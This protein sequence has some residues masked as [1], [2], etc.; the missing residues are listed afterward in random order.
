MVRSQAGISSTTRCVLF[1]GL[2]QFTSSPMT[3]GGLDAGLFPPETFSLIP[4]LYEP[5]VHRLFALADPSPLPHDDQYG[6]NT[7]FNILLLLLFTN[8]SRCSI[9]PTITIYDTKI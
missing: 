9:C 1:Y 2:P 4:I 8:T 7:D 5:A 6:L 3:W